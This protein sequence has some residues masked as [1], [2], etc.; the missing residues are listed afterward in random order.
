MEIQE[1]ED[2]LLANLLHQQRSRRYI[3]QQT[4]ITEQEILPELFTTDEESSESNESETNS[5]DN[6]GNEYT[7][8]FE[9]YSPPDYKLSQDQIGPDANN[10]LQFFWILLWIM[11]FHKR[12][13][14]PETATE[15]LI[16]FIKLL[17]TETSGSYYEEFLG[18]LYLARKVLGLKDQYYEFAACPKCHK[19]YNKKEVEEFWQDKNLTIMK[20]NHVEFPNLISR[21]SKQCQMPLS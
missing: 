20:C 10:N 18:S 17:L 7:E 21:R 8:I 1:M 5:D 2:D 11:S 12:F 4:T 6:N 14:I 19:L 16:Q 3:N 9:D 15:S 13:N